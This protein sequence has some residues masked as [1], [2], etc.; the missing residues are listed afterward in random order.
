MP[1][2]QNEYRHVTDQLKRR[3]KEARIGY[4]EL[5]DAIGISES[6]LKKF[7]TAKD[8]SLQ[9]VAE[10][11]HY[12]GISLGELY[13]DDRELAYRFTPEQQTAFLANHL[14][15]VL[16]WQLVYE[17]L[18]FSSVQ[19][20]INLDSRQGFR[21][22]RQLDQL[23]MIRLMPN[24]R[25][26]LPRIQAVKWVGEGPFIEKILKQWARAVIDDNCGPKSEEGRFFLIRY[27]R[28]T[29]KTYED[30][31][32]AQRNFENEF[33]HRAIREMIAERPGL[34]SV[35]WVAAVDRGRYV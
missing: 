15:F 30:F 24:G 7:M 9:R 26:R 25:I 18:P 21:L 34:K 5:A 4:R 20:E 19:K 23:K 3:L 12:L 28:M 2:A 22:L 10:V 17:R 27:L 8:G 14:L 1:K 6:G 32:Q 11:C 35:R 13:R 29:D 16:Y 33:V 31:L